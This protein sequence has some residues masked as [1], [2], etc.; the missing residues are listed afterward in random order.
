MKFKNVQ[1]LL[2]IIIT[3]SAKVLS[4][5]HSPQRRARLRPR[6]EHLHAGCRDEQRVFVLRAFLAIHG[7]RG[8]PVRPR[9]ALARPGVD[10]GLDRE[11]HTRLHRANRFVCK[12]KMSVLSRR[13]WV[14]FVTCMRDWV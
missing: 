7:Y 14:Y 9:H 5:F 13:V 3:L 8:P 10:H 2:H 12:K 11:G 6:R 1:P 4:V